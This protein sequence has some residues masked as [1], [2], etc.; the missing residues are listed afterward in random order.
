MRLNIQTGSVDNL[1]IT[2][3]S[4][5]LLSNYSPSR[6]DYATGREVQGYVA[7]DVG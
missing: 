6:V 7:L 5:P 1:K 4:R 2:A 3:L